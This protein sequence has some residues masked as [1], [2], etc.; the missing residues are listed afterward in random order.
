MTHKKI[1]SLKIINKHRET[2]D[3][4][5]F[6]LSITNQLKS[7]FQFLPGQYLTVYLT[8]NNVQHTRNY[9]I[10]S[11]SNLQNI[12]FCV[13]RVQNGLISNLLCDEYD[14]GGTLQISQ[15][16]GDFIL[17]DLFLENYKNLVFITGG[18]GITPLKSMIDFA[19]E[20]N[21]KG[22]IFLI[23][24]NRNKSSIIFHKH[25]K[26]IQKDNCQTLFTLDNPTEDWTGE[27]GQLTTSKIEEIF[28]KNN[29]PYK[30]TCF[31]TSGPPIIIDNV[32]NHLKTNDV[33]TTEIKFEKFFLSSFPG[34]R[35]TKPHLIKIKFKGETQRISIPANQNILDAALNSGI[36]I[37]HSCK[38]GNCLS[39]V[40]TLKSG[41]IHSNIKKKN[42]S[43]EILTCQSFPL[44][45]MVVLDFDKSIFQTSFTNRNT[46]M[47]IGFILSFVMLCFF[48]KPN[49]EYY[50]AKGSFNAGHNNLKC[51][52]CHKSAPG[53]TRQ[54]LQANMKSFLGLKDEYVPFGS[55]KAGNKECL[56]CHNRP[57]DVHPTHRFMEPKFI[58]ARKEIQPQNCVSCHNEHSGKRVTIEQIGFCVNCHK[59][60]KINNDPLDISHENLI[61]TNQ[62]STC[63]Q[64]HDFHG[65]H[66][67]QTPTSIK[68]TID[69]KK[70]E[71]YFEGGEDPYSKIKQYITEMN[72]KN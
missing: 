46:L 6:T 33:N 23:Y 21:F 41:Q 52:E 35:S 60:I 13:K 12:T 39:C 65:N 49:N 4:Y 64:C 62:W 54:Q 45:D 59:D 69:L 61:S 31:F 27:V 16:S 38:V 48:L 11:S 26:G 5:S 32:V 19:L 15:P 22:N 28:R 3:S 63:L 8:D 9:S 10:C 42:N 1:F 17:N 47:I 43:N 71:N 53:T 37:E 70:V 57:N 67:Y 51:I 24:A 36:D 58:S 18:S 30:D 68:D 20:N 44:N 55:L 72:E 66:I 14:V 56:S 25:L 40:A 7:Q 50:L 34:E 29:I 2:H